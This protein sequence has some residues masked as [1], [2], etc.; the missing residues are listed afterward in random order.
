MPKTVLVALLNVDPT[1]F[2]GGDAATFSTA[3][4]Q[5][6]AA[7]AHVGGRRAVTKLFVAPEYYFSQ[8]DDTFTAEGTTPK[9]VT[10]TQKHNIYTELKRVSSQHSDILMVA[11]SIF[12]KKTT[13]VFTKTT[14]GLNVCPVLLNGEFVYKYYKHDDDGNLGDTHPDAIYTHKKTDPFFTHDRVRY[15]IEI[16]KDHTSQVLK[17]W[18]AA[19]GG[20]RVDIHIYISATNTHQVSS[21]MAKTDGYVIHCDMTSSD[22][23]HGVMQQTGPS[24]TF[25]AGKAIIPLNSLAPVHTTGALGNGSTV[26]VYT[27]TI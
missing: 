9:P 17:G 3:C 23:K 7:L 1:Q 18:V 6:S 13:G 12:Y 26:S 16:C 8:M 24:V 21:L 22:R 11:G 27:L 10:R 15:G 20:A 4:T 14:K 5:A 25:D 2:S 19:H